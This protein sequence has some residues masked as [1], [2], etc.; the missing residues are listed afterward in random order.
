LIA[1]FEEG[2]A[3]A[4]YDAYAKEEA[5]AC[6]MGTVLTTLLLARKMGWSGPRLLR[7]A[8]SGDVTGD[9]QSVV[10]YAAMAFTDK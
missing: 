6:G 10:G 7:Y 5:E 1:L 2:N 4:I 3:D 8:N 9:K